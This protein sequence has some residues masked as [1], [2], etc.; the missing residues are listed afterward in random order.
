MLFLT[1][2]ITS[3]NNQSN[4]LTI[5]SEGYMGEFVILTNLA[6]AR[7]QLYPLLSLLL[8]LLHLSRH[9]VKIYCG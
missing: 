3:M 5:I 1:S 7:T 2:F 4:E 8:Y 9:P 6:V